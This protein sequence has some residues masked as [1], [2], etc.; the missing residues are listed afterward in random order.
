[1]G[2]HHPLLALSKSDQYG[3]IEGRFPSHDLDVGILFRI[4]EVMEMYRGGDDLAL[5]EALISRLAS[6]WEDGET[7]TSLRQSPLQK[8]IMAAAHDRRRFGWNDAIGPCHA[9]KQPP[10]KVSAGKQP[11]AGNLRARD[12][13]LGDEFVELAFPDPKVFGGFGGC[14][15]LQTCALLHMPARILLF[16]FFEHSTPNASGSRSYRI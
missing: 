11:L 16:D 12:L 14:Q 5:V 10:I 8:R 7:R 9:S 3:V 6:F 1:M 4:I 15:Q 2:N 13:P